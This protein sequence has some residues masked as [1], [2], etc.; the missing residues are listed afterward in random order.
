MFILLLTPFVSA[1]KALRLVNTEQQTALRTDPLFLFVSDEMPYAELL[2]VHEILDHTHSILGF[3]A[4]IQ[5]IQPVAGK[6][7]AA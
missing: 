6:S 3:I 1:K 7:L 5:V 2:H 4:L